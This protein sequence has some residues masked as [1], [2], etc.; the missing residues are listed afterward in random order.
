MNN[1]ELYD[2]LEVIC[3]NEIKEYRQSMDLPNELESERYTMELD[4]Y[5]LEEILY[6]TFDI[7]LCRFKQIVET[8]LPLCDIGKSD[9]T[10]KIYKDFAKK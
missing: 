1:L 6:D 3:E 10:N 4:K 9:L 7:N 2:L 5:D 8:L